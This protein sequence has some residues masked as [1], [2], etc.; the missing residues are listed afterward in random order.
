MTSN[1]KKMPPGVPVPKL[2]VEKNSFATN[3]M[4]SAASVNFPS[5]ITFTRLFPLPSTVG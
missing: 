2:P 1:G 4:A 3:S 5:L